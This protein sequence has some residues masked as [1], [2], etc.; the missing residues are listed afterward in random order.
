VGIYVFT[1]GISLRSRDDWKLLTWSEGCYE[2]FSRRYSEMKPTGNAA[3][4]AAAVY[5]LAFG[6]GHARDR[7]NL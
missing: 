6:V 1:R 4:K 5:D 3:E 7:S 2:V